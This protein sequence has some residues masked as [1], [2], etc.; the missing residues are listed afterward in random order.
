MPDDSL[1]PVARYDTRGD[2][3]LA[4]TQLEDAGIPSMLANA[5]QSSLP[6][7][8][9]ATEGGVQVKVAANRADEARDVLNRPD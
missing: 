3:Q 2:A 6:P 1:V 4:Q 8:F 5:T 9:D 7:M